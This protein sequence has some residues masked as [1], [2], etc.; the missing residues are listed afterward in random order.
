LLDQLEDDGFGVPIHAPD[1]TGV[2]FYHIGALAAELGAD[3]E[4]VKNL[5]DYYTKRN[6]ELTEKI[7]LCKLE[8]NND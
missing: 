3:H 7:V 8:K 1:T 5:V 4:L 6:Q 2:M